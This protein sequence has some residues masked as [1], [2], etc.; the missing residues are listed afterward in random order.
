MLLEKIIELATDTQQPLSVLLRQCILLGFELKNES[1]KTWANQELNGYTDPDALPKYRIVAAGATGVF[2]GG[3]AFPAE[4]RHIPALAMDEAHRDAAEIVRMAE[5][6]SAYE[7]H[8]KSDGPNLTYHWDANLIAYYQTRFIRG[9]ALVTASQLVSFG[10]IA[11]VLDTIRTRV[12]NMALEIREEIGESDADLKKAKADPVEAAKVN[13]IVVNNIY[14]G[15]VFMGGSGT[16]TVNVQNI[17][18]GNWEDLKKALTGVGI[19]ENDVDELSTAIQED[20]KTMGQ[21]VKNWIGRNAAKVFDHGLQL[22]TNV[23]TT[24]LTEYVKRHLGMS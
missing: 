20:G 1:L 14:G 18:V 23:G 6:V 8:L 22:S 5:P 21:R 19:A 9:Y 12:L 24:V 3:L 7:N 4:T 2:R 11:G 10:A 17:A 15:T 13:H 16:Q